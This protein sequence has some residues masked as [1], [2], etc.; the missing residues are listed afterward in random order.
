VGSRNAHSRQGERA[1]LAVIKI[2]RIKT[3][4]AAKLKDTPKEVQAAADQLTKVS[5]P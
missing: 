1:N 5:A 2:R 4:V 3:D